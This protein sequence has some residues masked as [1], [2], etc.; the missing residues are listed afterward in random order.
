M[1][2][3]IGPESESCQMSPALHCAF[4]CEQHGISN[5]WEK[6]T[7][8]C[9]VFG[10]AGY[11]LEKEKARVCPHTLD[12]ICKNKLQMVLRVKL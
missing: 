1:P 11:L 4:R 3:R 2:L 10:T 5:Q 6:Q 12:K 7:H 8:H 9:K